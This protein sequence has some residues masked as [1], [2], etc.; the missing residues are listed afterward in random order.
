[1]ILRLRNPTEG[2]KQY[3][4][5]AQFKTCNNRPDSIDDSFHFF[6]NGYRYKYS[7]PM[8]ARAFF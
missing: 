8:W 5:G 2:E 4:L 1:M 6:Q 3:L 7:C